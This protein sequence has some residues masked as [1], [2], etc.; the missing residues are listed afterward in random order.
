ME[1]FLSHNH[2]DRAWTERLGAQAAALG[3]KPYL[4]EHD[5]RPGP[6]LAEKVQ[7]EIRRSAAVVVLISDNSVNAA[8]V[9]QE[10]GFALAQRKIVVPLVQQGILVEALAMLQGVEYIS[11][12]FENPE[13]GLR[14]LNVALTGLIERQRK[15]EQQDALLALACAALI[16]FALYGG[17][18]G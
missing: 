17:S 11:F 4:A 9:Q 5:L 7:A 6:L 3:I 13:E 12:D 2:R 10:I 15:K 1:I 8:Y 14:G 16:I 18:G